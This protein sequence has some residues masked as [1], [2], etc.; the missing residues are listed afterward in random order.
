MSKICSVCGKEIEDNVEICSFCNN[1]PNNQNKEEL[2]QLEVVTHEEHSIPITNEESQASDIE[3]LEQQEIPIS[4][5]EEM[6]IPQTES[7]SNL[8]VPI[9]ISD[10]VIDTNSLNDEPT[11]TFEEIVVD[12]VDLETVAVEENNVNLEVEQQKI[13]MPEIPEATISEIN[14]DLLGNIYAESER[15]NNE[16]RVLKQQQEA[17]QERIRQEEALKNA[18]I[19]AARPDLLAGVNLNGEELTSQLPEQKKPKKGKILKV[20]V[21]LSIIIIILII[22]WFFVL[23]D[24]I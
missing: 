4:S 17:E 13:E 9:E 12:N 15:Q 7:N 22:L 18:S 21:T 2:S 20:I 3:L 19:P 1:Q 24:N 10:T 6:T 16:K 14:P 8:S 11:N 23:K 5:N